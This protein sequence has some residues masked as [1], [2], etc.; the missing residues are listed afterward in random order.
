MIA[1]VLK[2]RVELNVI[3]ELIV[4]VVSVTLEQ[5]ALVRLGQRIHQLALQPRRT[6]QRIHQQIP[7]QIRR[8]LLHIVRP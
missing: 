4:Q 2:G 6:L 5:T 3:K 8:H 1:S 7:R